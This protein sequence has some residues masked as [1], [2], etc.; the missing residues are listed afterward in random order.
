[1]V[2][3]IADVFSCEDLRLSSEYYIMS[4]GGGPAHFGAL[5]LGL[6]NIA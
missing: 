4:M 1:M 3:D 5:D 2:C 6:R